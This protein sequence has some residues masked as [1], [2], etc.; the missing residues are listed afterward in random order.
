MQTEVLQ[1][2]ELDKALYAIRDKYTTEED[3]AAMEEY[4]NDGYDFIGEELDA[5][6]EEI[7]ALK[8]KQGKETQPKG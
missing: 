7:D 5:L 4:M 1:G 8:E 6:E 2:E 3:R